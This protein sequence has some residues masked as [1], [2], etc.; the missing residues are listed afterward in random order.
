MPVFGQRALFLLLLISSFFY[1]QAQRRQQPATPKKDTSQ[2]SLPLVSSLM[3]FGQNKSGPKSYRDVIT[4]KAITSKGLFVIH[5]VEDKWYLELADSLLGRDILVVNRLSK[6]AAGMRNYTYGYAGDQIGNNVI[7]FE[8]GPNNKIF[9]KKISFDEI[10]RDT[11]QSMYRAVNNS[12][13]QPIVAAFDINAFSKD[14]ASYVIDITTYLNSDND[15]LNFAPNYKSAFQ[16]GSLQSDKS[17]TVAVKTYPMNVEI[18]TVKTYTK[19]G[20]G[21]G[22]QGAS[23]GFVSPSSN[24]LTMEINSSMLLLPKMPMRVRY[25]DERIGYFTRS[26]TD[27][28]ANPQGVKQVRMVTRWRLEPKDEDIERYKRGEL[29]EPKKPIIYYIDPATPRKWVP[30]LI[31]GVNDWQVA[32]EKAGFKNAI[33]AKVAPV[34]GEDSTWSLQDSRYSAIVYKP[35]NVENASGPSINDPRTGEILESHIN[36]YH[37]VMN[38]L[39][40]WYFI[41]AAAVDPRARKIK[42]DDDLMGELIRFVSSHEVGHTLGL[43]H[44]FGSSS[45][46]PVEKLRDKAWVEAN[47]HTPSI[48]DYARFNYVAQPEDSISSAGMYPRIGD[49]DKWAIEWGYRWYPDAKSAEEETKTLNKLTVERMKNKRLWFGEETNPDDPRSQSE[50]LSDNAAKASDYGIKNLQRIVQHLIEWTKNDDQYKDL[51]ELYNGVVDQ[52]GRYTEHVAKVIGGIMET[53]KTAEQEGAVY[54]YTTKTAQKEAMQFLNRQLFTTPTWL[55]N[56]KIASL[57]GDNSMTIIGSRQEA[58]LNRLTS[59]NNFAKLIKAEAA[60]GAKAYTM[61]DLLTDLQQ[62]VWTELS[63]H[64]PI[65]VYRR[66]LQKAYIERMRSIVGLSPSLSFSGGAFNFGSGVDT[67]KSDIISIVKGTLRTLNQDIKNALPSIQDKMTRYH[68]QDVQERID[69]ILY[70]PR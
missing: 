62:G 26:Y 30:Y 2:A 36:W 61:I 34:S 19:G 4:P 70:P 56:E 55:I 47:G 10:S 28:D 58:I 38:L 68:L 20:G 41:Q 8:R 48:M 21:F 57:I 66:N 33:Q 43:L 53:P 64:K 24:L 29:V 51:A 16:V 7:Q 31:K 44:N 69:L 40:N 60:Q 35:S 54:E 39:R 45:T 13:I 63:T 67:R 1:T 23:L 50:D 14:S 32:F 5:R 46:V 65:D 18:V 22:G 12:N 6:A 49:Y 52:Y 3:T 15:I 9:L 11:T 37:N 25:Y 27:F 42:F 59:G 17:Y